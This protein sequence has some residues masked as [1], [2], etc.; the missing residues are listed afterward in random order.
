MTKIKEYLYD[1]GYACAL[2]IVRD[3]VVID[4]APIFRKMIGWRVDRLRG[5]LEELS[6]E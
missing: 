6:Y 4:A 1:S 5:K 2:L 3:G